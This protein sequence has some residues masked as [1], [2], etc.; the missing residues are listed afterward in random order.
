MS[1]PNV[2][3]MTFIYTYL[4]VEKHFNIL[5]VTED[6]ITGQ[7]KIEAKGSFLLRYKARM[8]YNITVLSTIWGLGQRSIVIPVIVK[9]SSLLSACLVQ[10]YRASIVNLRCL[11]ADTERSESIHS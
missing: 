7:N 6:I 4:Y 10:V 5:T 2:K 3:F 11:P 1:A 8:T 9:C